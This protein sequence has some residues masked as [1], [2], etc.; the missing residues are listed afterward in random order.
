MTIQ[1]IKHLMYQTKATECHRDHVTLHG[2]KSQMENSVDEGTVDIYCFIRPSTCNYG[3]QCAAQC[4]KGIIINYEEIISLD[5]S[6]CSYLISEYNSGCNGTHQKAVYDN[7][8]TETNVQWHLSSYIDLITDNL[9]TFDE[10]ITEQRKLLLNPKKSVLTTNVAAQCGWADN[11]VCK[12]P[13]K[14]I[15]TNVN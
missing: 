1:S 4:P 2:M 3:N 10:F 13:L 6:E 11:I 9:M 15:F 5:K 12:N 7:Q 14:V 8:D